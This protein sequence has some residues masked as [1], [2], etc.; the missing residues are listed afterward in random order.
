MNSHL[1]M[2]DGHHYTQFEKETR[3]WPVQF[4]CKVIMIM[5]M[6][7]MMMTMLT[8]ATTAT[9]IMVMIIFFLLFGFISNFR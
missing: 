1:H 6:T 9:W 4:N 2:K 3:K 5:M 8:M 7:V